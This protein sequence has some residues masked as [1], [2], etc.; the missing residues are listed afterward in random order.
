MTIRCYSYWHLADMGLRPTNVHFRVTAEIE[1]RWRDVRYWH[2]ADIEGLTANVRFRGKADIAVSRLTSAND[3]N[4]CRQK[5]RDRCVWHW[6]RSLLTTAECLG[7]VGTGTARQLVTGALQAQMSPDVLQITPAT[8][9]GLSF[10][11]STRQF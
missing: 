8:T 11:R 1:I 2:K 9:C 4:R 7:T 5:T 10:R 3:L 6:Q